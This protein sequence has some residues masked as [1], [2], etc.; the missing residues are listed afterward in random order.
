MIFAAGRIINF[1]FNVYE[2]LIIIKVFMSWMPQRQSSE[3]TDLLDRV[4]DPILA[5]CRDFFFSAMSFLKID[6][7]SMPID[8]SPILAI[9]ILD[10]ARR[11]IL[12]VLS[13]IL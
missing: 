10:A 13:R 6:R 12:I 2:I 11:F 9:F 4:T 5:P 1:I 7:R 8:F 3:L